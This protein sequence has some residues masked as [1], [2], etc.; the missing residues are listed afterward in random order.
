[1]KITILQGAFLPVPPVMGGAVEK[2]WFLLGQRF[3]ELGHEVVHVSRRHDGMP[4]H[5]MLA[6]V[7]HHRVRG[8]DTPGNGLMLKALDGAYTLGALGALPDADILVTNTFWSPIL[9]RH[10]HGRTVVDVARMPKGQMRLYRRAACLRANSTPVRSAIIREDPSAAPRTRIIANP[11]TFIPRGDVDPKG[12]KPVLL[13]TGRIHPEK[14]IE[15]LLESFSS[16]PAS[17]RESW[18]LRLVGPAETRHGGGGEKWAASLAKRFENS[19][20]IHWVGPI[21]D[22]EALNREYREARFFVYPSLAEKGETFGL[23]PL[24][25]MAWGCVPL[26]SDLE[27]FKDFITDGHNGMI[28]DHR[29][30]AVENLASLLGRVCECSD[31]E[32]REWSGNCISVRESHSV[33]SIADQ[34]LEL[35]QELVGASD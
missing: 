29:Q 7:R 20:T 27:C 12:K 23:S 13:Y 26:V 28:F 11:L 2:M 6:G 34:F 35:F 22:A 14:G 19:G 24:E 30:N 5:E 15:L 9:A 16:L 8:F 33:A 21:F 1:M 32:F 4:A 18:E 25:A 10:R 31:A 17:V 3:A